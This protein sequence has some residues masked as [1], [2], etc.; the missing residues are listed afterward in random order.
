MR[1]TKDRAVHACQDAVQ[2]RL[3]NDGYVN[4]D[5]RRIDTDDNPGRNDWI[6]GNLAASRR[7]GDR[8]RF[9]FSCSVDFD[10]GRIRSI[11]VN[12]SDRR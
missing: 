6:V 2:D 8:D 5:V 9:E 7:D 4:F 10:N 12:R 3:R 11:N 1:Y